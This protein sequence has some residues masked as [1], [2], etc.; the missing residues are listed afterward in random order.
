MNKLI[1]LVI[2]AV[3]VV[4]VAALAWLNRSNRIPEETG[5]E[6][7]SRRERDWYR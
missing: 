2:G 7:A 6:R 1:S 5:H 4:I 3:V